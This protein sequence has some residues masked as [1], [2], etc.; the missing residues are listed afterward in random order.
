MTAL[1]FS[2]LKLRGQRRGVI[3]EAELGFEPG[4]ACLPAGPLIP[5]RVG[6]VWI[7]GEASGWAWVGGKSQGPTCPR[8]LRAGAATKRNTR[9]W[10]G[11]PARRR[12]A[13]GNKHCGAENWSSIC[14]PARTALSPF[15]PRQAP[16]RFI[17][18]NTTM[19]PTALRRQQAL[20]HLQAGYTRRPAHTRPLAART[21]PPSHSQGN[22][23]HP[24]FLCHPLPRGPCP[25]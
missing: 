13:A 23:C 2:L 12:F 8:R 3:L 6:C 22:T 21:A 11:D 15:R 9:S 16:L 19:R 17:I 1:C 14:R 10:A 7:P 20:S 25:T 4:A 24:L 18:N 5:S